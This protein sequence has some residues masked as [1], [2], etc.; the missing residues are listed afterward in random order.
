MLRFGGGDPEEGQSRGHGVKILIWCPSGTGEQLASMA[1]A[2]S[3][4]A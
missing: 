4:R 3:L 1:A 2:A